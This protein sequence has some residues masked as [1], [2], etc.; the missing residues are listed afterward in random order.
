MIIEEPWRKTQQLFHLWFRLVK[1]HRE[2]FSEL[3]R[4]PISVSGRLS[5]LR[6]NRLL[7]G[8]RLGRPALYTFYRYRQAVAFRT[9]CRRARDRL[10]IFETSTHAGTLESSLDAEYN[11]SSRGTL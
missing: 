10:K 6:I 3:R 1:P 7:A 2:D 5:V 9:E 4:T 11:Q 8:A